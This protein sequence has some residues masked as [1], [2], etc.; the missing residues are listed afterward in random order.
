MLL[1]TYLTTPQG[2]L[3]LARARTAQWPN[4]S[5]THDAYDMRMHAHARVL[6]GRVVRGHAHAEDAPSGS[7]NVGE[8]VRRRGPTQRT[9]EPTDESEDESDTEHTVD[10]LLWFGALPPATLRDA[11]RAYC[12]ALDAAVHVAA[13][14]DRV[15]TLLRDYE[16]DY[17]GE[18]S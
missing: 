3:S 1:D 8:G 12:S 17:G 5:L 9:S 13:L 15:T 14:Q 7:G 16:R 11:Q 4:L 6:D 10:P 2:G 18:S